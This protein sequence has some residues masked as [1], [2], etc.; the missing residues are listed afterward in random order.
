MGVVFFMVALS[1][2]FILGIMLVSFGVAM[3]I[4]YGA[5]KIKRKALF[6]IGIVF[7]SVGALT[8]AIF[9]VYVSGV[10]MVAN[11][12]YPVKGQVINQSGYQDLSFSVG[13]TTYKRLN[14]E[15]S[16]LIGID[17]KTPVFTYKQRFFL[18]WN[19]VSGYY[20]E[21]NNHDLKYP[22]Y[23]SDQGHLFCK[24]SDYQNAT[25]YYENCER[26]WYFFEY[27]CT[28]EEDALLS[29]LETVDDMFATTVDLSDDNFD[30]Y[31]FT[32]ISKDKIV[33]FKREILIVKNGRCYLYLDNSDYAY[34]GFESERV[35]ALSDDYLN[36]CSRIEE[37][38]NAN[39]TNT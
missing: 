39:Q 15:E 22:L 6:I 23:V 8:A 16:M 4:I 31:M 13:D 19:A 29:Y 24:E 28:A 38:I 35:L 20:Y 11:K 26:K 27:E 1:M 37:I 14:F 5:K 33:Q 25:E 36:L 7:V 32:L 18:F 9:P 21:I 2:L 34:G 3:L 17:D 10:T 12:T 30:A